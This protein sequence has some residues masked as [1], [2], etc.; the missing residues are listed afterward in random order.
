[1]KLTPEQMK[2]FSSE[3][4]AACDEGYQIIVEN[5]ND[6]IRSYVTDL[7]GSDEDERFDT[8]VDEL[9]DLVEIPNIKINGEWTA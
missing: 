2:S 3:L 5:I 8:V 9:W 7:L 6:T 4:N 1:M